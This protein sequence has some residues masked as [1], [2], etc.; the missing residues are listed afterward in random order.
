MEC[1]RRPDRCPAVSP[2]SGR[3]YRA[4]RSRRAGRRQTGA[5]PAPRSAR[6]WGCR[7]GRRT[8]RSRPTRRFAAPPANG[9][10]SRPPTPRR[11]DRIPAAPPVRPRRSSAAGTSGMHRNPSSAPQATAV[12]PRSSNG[13]PSGNCLV[14]GMA[15]G[16]DDTRERD[17]HACTDHPPESSHSAALEAKAG[18]QRARSCAPRCA[19]SSRTTTS[20]IPGSHPIAGAAQSPPPKPA[21]TLDEVSP[22]D[23]TR[24]ASPKASTPRSPTMKLSRKRRTRTRVS[25]LPYAAP[26]SPAKRSVSNPRA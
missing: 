11:P 9:G 18:A 10:G 8:G 22:R 3:A 16:E 24:P 4:T 1:G 15:G 26:R 21:W 25:R 14:R 6:L 12:S 2:P 23:Q 19:T 20:S 5:T 7:C 17:P 13:P